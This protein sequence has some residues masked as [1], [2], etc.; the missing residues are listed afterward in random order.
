MA[1][2]LRPKSETLESEKTP[3]IVVDQAAKEVV[4]TAE[5]QEAA[6]A[7]AT[8]KRTKNPESWLKTKSKEFF[9]PRANLNAAKTAAGLGIFSV[10]KMFGALIKFAKEAIMRKGEVGFGKG[11][12]IGEK[13]FGSE[14]K[15]KS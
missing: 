3:E 14:K 10:F 4:S 15:D 5:F 12:E 13:I 6:S 1:E 11:F 9:D 8:S 2:T 7:D